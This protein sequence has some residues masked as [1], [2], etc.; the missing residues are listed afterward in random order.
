MYKYVFP[1]LKWSFLKQKFSSN[2]CTQGMQYSDAWVHLVS[3]PAVFRLVKH[4][5]KSLILKY[6]LL[7]DAVSYN[8]ISV[9]YV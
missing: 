7:F 1:S 6:A 2:W 5:D 3:V 4:R 9:Y 8:G